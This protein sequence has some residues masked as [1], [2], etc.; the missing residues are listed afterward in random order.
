R[1]GHYAQPSHADCTVADA[2]GA[3]AGCADVHYPISADHDRPAFPP[4]GVGHTTDAVQSG[5]GWTLYVSVSA[6][7]PAHGHRDLSHR[8]GADGPRK[9]H[10]EPGFRR[11]IQA[12]KNV[13]HKIRPRKGHPTIRRGGESPRATKSVRP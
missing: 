10:R 5:V 6:D 13:S 11:R 12:P 7:P 8:M 4:S 9:T 1:D 3:L 2:D